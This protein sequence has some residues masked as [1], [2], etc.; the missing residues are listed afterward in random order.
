MVRINVEVEEDTREDWKK[1]KDN[2][3][4]YATVSQLVRTA[5][6]NQIE[7][8]REY[9]EPFNEVT[10]GSAGNTDEAID[11]LKED[12]NE[13][14]ISLK[15]DINQLQV[16]M[17]GTDDD[18][19]LSNLM[20]EFHDI[21]PRIPASDFDPQQHSNAHIDE[22][23]AEA[24]KS[25]DLTTDT[26]DIDARKALEQLSETVPTVESVR[27]EGERYYFEK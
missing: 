5:V 24:R 6:E 21:L 22:I 15:S 12:L 11:E 2:T 16:Q 1:H 20:S 19:L 9:G 4:K 27:I 26:R 23:I 14:L 10:A 8:D 3:N 25:G 13:T 17:E 18:T 7:Y